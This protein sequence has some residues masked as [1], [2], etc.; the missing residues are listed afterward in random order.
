MKKSKR[1]YEKQAT[2]FD[3]QIK[4]LRNRGVVIDNDEKTKECLADIGYYRLGFYTF[5]FEKT[6]PDLTRQRCHEVKKE[7]KI[8]DIVG[9]YYFDFDLRNILNKY[10][11]RIEV[12][13]RTTMVYE[14]SN[15]YKEDPAWF[16]NNSIVSDK[17]ID[18]FRDIYKTIKERPVIA[19]HHQYYSCKYAPAWKTME[20]MTL[21][22][23]EVLYDCLLKDEDKK[24]ICRHFDEPKTGVF[25]SYLT[26]I[27]EVRN[28][29]AHG[30]ILFGLT[31]KNGIR[32]GKAC[33]F[34]PKRANQ[35]FYG[36]LLVI[37][38]FLKQ[39]SLNRDKDMWEEI[40]RATTILYSKAPKLRELIE[41]KTGIILPEEKDEV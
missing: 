11:S 2:T 5:P 23:L 13:I 19:R 33:K 1:P 35:N 22:N 28:A 14:L 10:L 39:V 32:S 4:L 37:D 25:K 17:F 15:K 12:A 38:Y 34:F 31:L 6:Y 41:M 16:V 40:Y 7:T 21:G 36:A 29:C 9:L 3:E 8:E 18:G 30:N 27:R 26:T 24:I 20:F